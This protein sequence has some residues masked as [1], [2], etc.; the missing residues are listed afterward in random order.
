MPPPV[1]GA[2][3]NLYTLVLGVL[4]VLIVAMWIFTARYR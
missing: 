1:L 3:R 4:V 2:W